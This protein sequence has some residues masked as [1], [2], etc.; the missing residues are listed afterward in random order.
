MYLVN[1]SDS[2]YLKPGKSYS[3]KVTK[4]NPCLFLS[5]KDTISLCGSCNVFGDLFI[6]QPKVRQNRKR[7]RKRKNKEVSIIWKFGKIEEVL[8]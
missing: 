8:L 3:L 1:K 2:I 5:G 4:R 6:V 7:K